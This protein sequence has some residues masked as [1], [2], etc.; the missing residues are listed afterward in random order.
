ML[1]VDSYAK[2]FLILYPSLENSTTRIAIDQYTLNSHAQTASKGGRSSHIRDGRTYLLIKWKISRFE[3]K[4][5]H[6][7]AG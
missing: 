6:R 3:A 2:I 4:N 1:N 7:R 5:F